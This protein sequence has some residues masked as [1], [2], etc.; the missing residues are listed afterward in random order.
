MFGLA[1]VVLKNLVVLQGVSAV[2]VGEMRGSRLRHLTISSLTRGVAVA[3]RAIMGTE[4]SMSVLF[5]QPSSLY[6]GLKSWP[7]SLTQ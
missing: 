2:C 1:V 5:S 7:H 3:V 4:G 6:A